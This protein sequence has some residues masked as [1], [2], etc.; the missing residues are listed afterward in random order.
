VPDNLH[1]PLLAAAVL[2]WY[3]VYALRQ[4]RSGRADVPAVVWRE[5]TA[6]GWTEWADLQDVSAD[7]G[8]DDLL[9]AARDSAAPTSTAVQFAVVVNPAGAPEYTLRV[10]FM[11]EA[12][13]RFAARDRLLRLG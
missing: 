3:L 7:T 2:I 10:L 4:A 5:A 8:Y 9:A 11:S 12:R 6:D 1:L 13:E